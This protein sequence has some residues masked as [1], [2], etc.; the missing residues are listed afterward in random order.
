MTPVATI[1]A[2]LNRIIDDGSLVGAGLECSVEKIMVVPDI[3]PL[4]G[5]TSVRSCFVWESAF[6]GLHGE[7]SSLPD[8]AA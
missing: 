3:E 2:V 7:P 6:R 1:V 8:A 5:Y 4:N